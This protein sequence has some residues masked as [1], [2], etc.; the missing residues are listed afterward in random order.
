MGKSKQKRKDNKNIFLIIIALIVVFIVVY[1][2]FYYG[3]MKRTVSSYEDKIYP[4]V[5]VEGIEMGGKTKDEAIKLSNEKTKELINNDIKVKVKDKEY[6]IDYDRLSI[7]SNLQE[8]IMEALNHGKNLSIREGYK[9]IKNPKKV[10]FDIEYSYNIK[11][12][13]SLLNEIE[14]TFNKEV[15]NA[16]IIKEDGKLK[17]SESSSKEKINRKDFISRVEEAVKSNTENN[18]G[19]VT[20]EL[21]ISIEE[22]N[23]ST[24]DLQRINTIISSFSTNFLDDVIATNIKVATVAASGIVLM[25][26]EEYSFN[27]LVGES[28]KEKG[29]VEVPVIKDNKLQPELGGGICQVSTTLH[30]AIIRA[31]ILPTEITHHSMPVGYVDKGM[32]ATIYYNLVD[33]KFKNTLPYPIYI[34]AI[35]ENNKIIF[36]IYSYKELANRKYEIIS[37]VYEEIPQKIEYKKDIT[38]DEGEEKVENLG[39]KGYKVKVYRKTLENKK[40]V[41]EEVICDEI[42][43]PINKIIRRNE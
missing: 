7:K 38:L 3:Y 15:R 41:K 43:K 16:T 37:K 24:E 9:L 19:D 39:S 22:P 31:G 2:L 21:P 26:E 8:T 4:Q 14:K 42:Y 11:A 32:D 12:V 13:D 25:P 18:K 1:L 17:V 6:K 30:N 23:I 29:Y 35:V 33:Y 10:D 20:L 36:N 40:E 27:K 28:T 5:F 34:D